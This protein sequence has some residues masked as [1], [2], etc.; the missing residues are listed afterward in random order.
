MRDFPD[1]VGDLRL[2]V[3]G[4][5]QNQDGSRV[6]SRWCVHGL[7][8]G[9][10]GTEAE[11]RPVSFTGTAVWAVREDG[12]LLHNWVERAGWELYRRLTAAPS[13]DD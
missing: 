13:Q 2:E 9:V 7:N 5:F 4:T 3:T 6:A 11:G 10:M 12:K 1:Q 8:N